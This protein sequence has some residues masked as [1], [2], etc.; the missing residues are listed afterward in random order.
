MG[1]GCSGATLGVVA[2]KGSGKDDIHGLCGTGENCSGA[3]LGGGGAS[4]ASPPIVL[5]KPGMIDNAS[6]FMVEYCPRS[7]CSVVMLVLWVKPLTR[8]TCMVGALYRM[9]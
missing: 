9:S 1:G 3:E 5:L 2:G 6:K 8:S 7:A 4:C